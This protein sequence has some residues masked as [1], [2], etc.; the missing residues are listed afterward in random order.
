ME[1]SMEQIRQ[2][3]LDQ[4]ARPQITVDQIRQIVQERRPRRH[5]RNG[6][7]DG[8]DDEGSDLSSASIRSRPRH[9][10][11][12][13]DRRGGIFGGR[14]RLEIPVFKGEDAYGWLVRVER[15][16]RIYEIRTQEKV[17]AVVLAM[18][19]RALN[20]FQWWEEKVDA[21]IRRFQP[22][23]LNNPLGPLLSHK[24]KTTVKEYRDKFELLAELKLYDSQDLA[25]IMDRALLI[26]EKNEVAG[27]RST[28]WKDRGGTYKFKDPGDMSNPKKESER[29][30]QDTMTELG[31]ED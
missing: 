18:E 5:R 10:H 1:A 14:R 6:D 20:W 7:G 17:D 27:R 2:L 13:D 3:V 16:F 19:D 9:R 26:E 25:E 11:G 21:V 12:N 28:G 22:G 23:L 30:E 4:Q 24:Q 29:G 8:D 15:Y 31:E